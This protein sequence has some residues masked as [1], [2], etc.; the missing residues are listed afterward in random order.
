MH[1]ND[2]AIYIA[3]NQRNPWQA[4]S[5]HGKAMQS[6]QSNHL[7]LLPYMCRY[8]EADV[9]AQLGDKITLIMLKLKS[10]KLAL[11]INE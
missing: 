4:N 7:Q 8:T 3:H 10:E 1:K 9:Y 2:A 6:D 5:Q 11:R